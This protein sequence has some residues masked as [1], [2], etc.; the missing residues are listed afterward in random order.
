MADSLLTRRD[1]LVKSGI[2]GAL[3]AVYGAAG[4]GG[5]PA[6]AQTPDD[7]APVIAALRTTLQELARDTYSGLVAFVVPGP[8]PY[9]VAQGV[10]TPKPGGI[11]ARNVDF[12]VAAIDDFVPLPD[13][14]TNA[15]GFALSEGLR[16]API[17]I[18]AEL[19]GIPLMVTEQLDEAIRAYTENDQVLPLSLVFAL[20]MN[21]A[22]V[23]V[24]PLAVSG[25]FLSPF[26]R[27]TYDE[28]L[29]AMA[30]IEGA[31]ADLVATI[32]GG[33]PEPE[34]ESISGILRFVGGALYEF[35]AFGTFSEYGVFDPATRKLTGRPVG[36]AMSGYQ[37]N[38]P[39]EGWDE[40]KGYFQGRK[41]VSG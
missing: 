12:M 15:Y 6:W 13:R 30:M 27:L 10:T 7:L 9:S 8:D 11:A 17:P 26:A 36:W 18:P 29:Q 28:K 23:A 5:I 25:A 40:F 37:P 4:P 19:A 32:D 14:N 16:T 2:L 24:N 20:A 1:F 21:Q 35:V 33:L 41:Q 22:A 31:N 34:T 38:G 3:V 39:V